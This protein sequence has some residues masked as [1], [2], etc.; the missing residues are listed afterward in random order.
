MLTVVPNPQP[1]LSQL[2]Q[3]EAAIYEAR[4]QLARAV[5]LLESLPPAVADVVHLVDG[6]REARGLTEDVLFATRALRHRAE[7]GRAS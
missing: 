5:N 6:T 4:A 2:T 7:L 1:D 3:A